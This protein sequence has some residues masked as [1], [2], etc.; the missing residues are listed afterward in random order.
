MMNVISQFNQIQFKYLLSMF[1]FKMFYNLIQARII[2][3]S[4]DSIDN[5][6]NRFKFSRM[7]DNLQ[8]NQPRWKELSTF[9]VCPLKCIFLFILSVCIYYTTTKLMRLFRK[10][11]VLKGN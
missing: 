1:F 11:I 8:I 3:T 4:P 7:L 5:A 9:E 10:I 6:E 2:G